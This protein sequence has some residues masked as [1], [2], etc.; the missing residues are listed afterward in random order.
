MT[1]HHTGSCL[2]GH[3]RFTAVGAPQNAGNCHCRMCQKAS[4]AAYLTLVAFPRANVTW[5]GAEPQWRVSSDKAERAFCPHCGGALAF[6]F[7][8]SDDIDLALTLFDEPNA[9]PPAFDIWTESRRGWVVLDDHL[10]RYPQS[11]TR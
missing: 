7:L 10:P 3:V 11:R 8:G 1:E 2:C 9:F 6:R 5:T 4:G